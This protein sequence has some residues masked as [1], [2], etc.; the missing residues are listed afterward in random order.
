MAG[1]TVVRLHSMDILHHFQKKTM[2]H[3]EPYCWFKKNRHA[4]K[5]WVPPTASMCFTWKSAIKMPSFVSC[6]GM[7]PCLIGLEKY[8]K[9]HQ[10]MRRRVLHGD[11]EMFGLLFVVVSRT[12]DMQHVATS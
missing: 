5:Q 10:R 2:T 11:H 3:H 1:N 6:R 4:G 9:P 7:S 12:L 8:G